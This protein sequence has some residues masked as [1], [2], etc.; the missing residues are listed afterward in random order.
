MIDVL[1]QG[2]AALVLL[3]SAVVIGW[4]LYYMVTGRGMTLRDRVRENSEL[5]LRGQLVE[6]EHRQRA[7]R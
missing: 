4:L 1:A 3:A 5:Q 2:L 6:R 7:R